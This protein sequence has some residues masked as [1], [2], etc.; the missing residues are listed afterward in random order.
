MRRA[1]KWADWGPTITR[2]R[3][4]LVQ[5]GLK[6]SHSAYSSRR[7]I[8]ILSVG[9]FVCLKLVAGQGGGRPPQDD[10]RWGGTSRLALADCLLRAPQRCPTNVTGGT[11]SASAA[12]PLVPL[13]SVRLARRGIEML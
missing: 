11:G 1:Q 3:R 4:S 7:P 5:S 13:Q 12:H 9:N 6:P 2:P 8:V 10:F